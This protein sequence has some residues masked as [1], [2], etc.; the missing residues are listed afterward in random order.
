VI[1]KI[2]KRRSLTSTEAATQFGKSPRT[3]RRLVAE[4]RGDYEARA[5]AR[6]QQANDLRQQGASWAEVAE[7]MACSVEAAK[8]LGKRFK[9]F[10]SDFQPHQ[11]FTRHP[12]KSENLRD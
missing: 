8:Q 2:A 10:S 1:P 7:V 5:I 6:R 9:R 4:D 12:K 3:I 11:K